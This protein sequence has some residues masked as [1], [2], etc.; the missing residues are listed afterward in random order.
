MNW[1]TTTPTVQQVKDH[2]AAHPA[3]N[4]SE[5][6]SG[7]LKYQENLNSR[8]PISDVKVA[9]VYRA[10][11]WLRIW[12]VMGRPELVRLRVLKGR[13]VIQASP[14]SHWSGMSTNAARWLPLTHLGLPV[15]YDNC[16]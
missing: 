1:L 3:F 8:N 4:H 13:V 5:G 15:D 14:F 2:A 16:G 11:L 12:M 9:D 7:H 6:R 10:G